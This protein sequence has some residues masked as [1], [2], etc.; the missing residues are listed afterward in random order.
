VQE[1]HGEVVAWFLIN[2]NEENRIMKR[3]IFNFYGTGHEIPDNPGRYLGTF[4][5]KGGM[6]VFHLFEVF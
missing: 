4:Q 2:A 1:Q 3:R 6:L 5:L